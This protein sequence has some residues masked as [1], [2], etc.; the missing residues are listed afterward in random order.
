MTTNWRKVFVLANFDVSK[1]FPLYSEYDLRIVMAKSL[2][3]MSQIGHAGT[4][5][6]VTKE[7][8]AE[9]VTTLSARG[10]KKAPHFVTYPQRRATQPSYQSVRRAMKKTMRESC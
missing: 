9:E 7:R 4:R 8:R 6:S 2:K 3:T 10:S 1:R 5:P